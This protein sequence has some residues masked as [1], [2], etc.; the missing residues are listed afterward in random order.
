MP[1]ETH[2]GGAPRPRT[3]GLR[4]SF[5]DGIAIALCIAVTWLAWPWIGSMALVFPVALGHFF[6]FC[7]VFRIPRRPELIWTG[8]F[9]VNAY[10]WFFAGRFNW[11][12]VLAVQTPLTIFFIIRAMLSP[13]YHGI[14]ANWINRRHIQAYLS[15][16]I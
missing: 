12:G 8:V 14:G 16:D 9:I 10:G 6:L 2:K 7:N 1:R 13:S 4:F 5:A 15:G 11:L 3:C